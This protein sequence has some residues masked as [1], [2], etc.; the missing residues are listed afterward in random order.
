MKNMKVGKLKFRST[1]NCTE[2]SN[3]VI[4]QAGVRSLM[5]LGLVLF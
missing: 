4:E 1:L 5:A 2:I 3:E